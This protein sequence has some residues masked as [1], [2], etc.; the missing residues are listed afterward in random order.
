MF[1]TEMALCLNNLSSLSFPVFVVLLKNVLGKLP[2]FNESV[3]NPGIRTL[4]QFPLRLLLFW[5]LLAKHIVVIR[6]LAA[7][8]G[9]LNFF[10]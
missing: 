8:F 7:V 6:H 2:K 10:I 4:V 9:G 5:S 1:D 3:E